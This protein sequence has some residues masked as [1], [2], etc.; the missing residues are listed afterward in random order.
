MLLS[1]WL[2]QKIKNLPIVNLKKS[3]FFLETHIKDPI[4]ITAVC[5]FLSLITKITTTTCMFPQFTCGIQ[6]ITHVKLPLEQ[7]RREWTTS[8]T[9]IQ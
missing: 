7:I 6:S 2:T 9:L 4:K 8:I 5:C 3:I 1:S